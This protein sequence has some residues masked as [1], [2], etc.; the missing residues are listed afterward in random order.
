MRLSN[1]LLIVLMLL[2][3]GLLL[4]LPASG[5]YSTLNSNVDSYVSSSAPDNN[6][7]SSQT[8]YI[9][10]NYKALIKFDLS[11]YQG[12]QI[13]YARL[14]IYVSG[15]SNYA[16]AIIEVHRILSDWNESEVTYNTLPNY[17]N[18]TVSNVTISG[19]N[20]WYE[21]DLTNDIQYLIDNPS[22][23]YGWIL[24]WNSDLT[25]Y[26]TIHSKEGSNPPILEIYYIDGTS[27]T[28]TVTSTTTEIITE[29]IIE[30]TT[31]TETQANATIT[32]T[33]TSTITSPTTVTQ[34]IYSTKTEYQNASI[35]A[36][37]ITSSLGGLLTSILP[38]LLLIGVVGAL[39]KAVRG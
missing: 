25:G 35:N 15:G 27:A 17:L 37:E 36:S 34:T 8:L 30:T 11:Q 9:G 6:Y 20:Q 21:F 2:I 14:K 4:I 31:V 28:V 1:K 22:E 13:A 33:V 5:D 12:K 7:G 32:K 10:T 38:L 26:I 23:N 39:A 24:I 18:E 16:N 19:I 3:I 29:T